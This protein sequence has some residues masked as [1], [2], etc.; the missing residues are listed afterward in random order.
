MSYDGEKI[1][2]RLEYEGQKRKT[3]I[4]LPHEFFHLKKRIGA[5]KSDFTSLLKLIFKLVIVGI[6]FAANAGLLGTIY[7]HS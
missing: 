1:W 6:S 7:F 3:K 5:E 2:Y 4:V